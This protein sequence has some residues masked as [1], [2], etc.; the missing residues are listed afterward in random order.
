MKYSAVLSSE[1][2]DEAARHLLRPDQQEDLCFAL[3]Y[4][5]KGVDRTTAL[6]HSLILPKSGER[7]VHG[8]ASFKPA[9]FERALQ[10]AQIQGAGLAFM[11][12]HLGPGWQGMSRADIQAEQ[13]KAAAVKAATGLPFVGLTLATDGAWSARFWHKTAPK[14]YERAWCETVRVVGERGLEVTFMD[15]L[16]PPPGF[17]ERQRRTTTAWGLTKQQKLA[18]LT[19]GIVGA[20]S[21]GSIVAE[22]L[23]R[24][25]VAHIKLLDFDPVEELN[26]DRV[27]HATEADIGRSK[28]DVL[29]EAL[30][31]SATAEGFVADVLRLSVTEEEGFRAALDCDVLFSCVD[32]PWPR[33][34]LNLIAYAHCIP[35]IDGGIAVTVK[36]NDNL[37]SADWKVHSV[38]PG[39]RCLECLGQYDSALIQAER[40]GYFEDPVYIKSLADDHPIK[41]NQNVFAFSLDTA[42]HEI[43]QLLALVIAPMGITDIG[44]LNY[45]FKDGSID[46][47]NGAKCQPECPYPSFTSQGDSLG[48]VVT[49]RH[50]AAEA[51]REKGYRH[52]NN[53]WLQKIYNLIK[54]L[55]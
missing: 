10:L 1:I 43:L 54:N 27:L 26:L 53:S 16:L 14:T 19:V 21:V 50:A 52:L 23:A 49:G 15:T 12:S 13:T 24:I 2:H 37:H 41:Q 38:L 7:A 42:A 35:V 46:I 55:A 29:A 8:N 22:S 30:Y 4:P 31:K 51:A 34:V 25:G 11:H 3:W 47:E 5:S 40:E 39:R 28:V 32:R 44:A 20:G 17:R 48:L 33:G 9:Y 6:I 45:H 18:R 36:K